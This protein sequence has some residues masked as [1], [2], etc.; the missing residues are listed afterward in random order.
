MHLTVTRRP[1]AITLSATLVLALVVSLAAVRPASGEDWTTPTELGIGSEATGGHDVAVN[2]AGE[3]AAVWIVGSSVRASTRT[4]GAAWSG[5]EEIGS[6]PSGPGTSIAP[7]VF[8]SPEGIVHAIWGRGGEFTSPAVPGT[9]Q[10]RRRS[11]QG[12]W[13]PVQTYQSPTPIADFGATLTSDGGLVLHWLTFGRGYATRLDPAGQWAPHHEYP[14][15][16]RL[17]AAIASFREGAGATVLWSDFTQPSSTYSHTW[18]DGSWEPSR[19]VFTGTM[20]VSTVTDSSPSGW[21]VAA[22]TT[23]SVP[24]R[25][26]SPNGTWQE[27]FALPYT[28]IGVSVALTESNQAVVAWTDGEAGARSVRAALVDP[29]SGPGPVTTLSG[30]GTNS[31]PVV[32]IG[33]GGVATVAWSGPSGTTQAVTARAWQAD[34]GWGEPRLLGLAS[35]ATPPALS[36]EGDGDAILAWINSAGR[37]QTRT[38]DRTPP[39]IT[40][41]AWSGSFVNEPIQFSATATDTWSPVSGATWDLGGGAGQQGLTTSHAF[42]EAGLHPVSLTVTDAAGN[43]STQQVLVTVGT[44]DAPVTVPHQPTMSRFA[45]DR[46]KIRLKGPKAKRRTTAWIDLDGSGRVQI[47]WSKKVVKVRKGKK[48]TV[49]KPVGTSA[50]DM[51]PGANRLTLRPKVGSKRLK[52]GRYVLV[53][54]I[55]QSSR[56]AK[57]RVTR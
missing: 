48:R 17:G 33:A 13:S 23:S 51:K 28:A 43:S 15:G 34:A 52:V 44:R 6:V 41:L 3:A 30:P 1:R 12:T 50:Y 40:T 53:A 24:V 9:F 36:G 49:L 19:Q 11:P 5:W 22:D 8:L 38:L 7:R 29:V 47:Q 27:P 20:T 56:T 42:T 2:T 57:L 14:G 10:S 26:R 4:P 46:R 39:K 37:L 45:L 25:F 16:D 31:A 18:R 35:G 32:E 54:T 21:V 55:G